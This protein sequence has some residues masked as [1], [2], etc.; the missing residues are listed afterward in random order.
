MSRVVEDHPLQA[1]RA[2]AA[3]HAWREAFD[4]LSESDRSE[5][6]APNDLT[7]LGDAAWWL[8]RLDESIAIKER[9]YAGYSGAGDRQKAAMCAL[10]LADLYFSK[11]AHSIG[12]GWFNRAERLL[13][14]EP[15]SAA[16]G[17]LAFMH[18]AGAERS[19]DLDAALA[20]G[21]RTLDLGTRFGDRDLQGYG[22][23]L[24]GR[25]LVLKGQVEEGLAL[26]DEATVAAVSGEIG[27]LATGI[28]YCLAISTTAALADYTR[29]GEWTDASKRWC[30]RQ[31]ISGFPGVCRVHRAE[32]MRLRG[33]WAEAEQEARRALTELERFNLEFAA[34][35]FYELGEIRLRIGD[36]ADAED[37]F[38]QAHEL[39]RPPYPGLA[40]LWLAQGK[41]EAAASAMRRALDDPHFDRLGR[42]RLLPAEVEVALALEDFERA[43]SAV[44]EL[45]E[46]AEHFDSVPLLASAG[47]ARG[48]LLLAQGDT[49][50]AVRTLESA[51]RLW[52]Q[53]DLPYEA[54]RT[55]MMLGVALRADGDDGGGTME[56]QAARSAFERLGA[57]LDLQAVMELLGGQ[58]GDGQPKASPPG[59]RVVKTMMFTDIVSSTSLLEAI[60][61]KAWEGVLDWHDQ[62]L[63]HLFAKHCGEEVKHAGDGFFVAFDQ[64]T[65]ALECA[66]EIQRRLADHRKNHGFAPQVRIGLHR[67]EATRKGHDYAGKGVHVAARVSAL[68]AA[69]EIL[70]TSDVMAHASSRFPASA[71]RTV[72]LKGVSDPVEVVAVAVSPLSVGPGA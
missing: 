6:L 48:A 47:C 43:G 20:L 16:H 38:R 36:L 17:Y 32:I 19:G 44:A 29:A 65:E 57:V 45:E 21:Q 51:W 52:K 4:L 71:P 8:G 42:C 27:P 54:A 72:A 28:I 24:R 10:S 33:S 14:D 62:T 12:A 34:E 55:R 30:E 63:R 3:K 7:T 64:A 15:E 56:I 35:G 26:L 2:A 49:V 22:L 68:A 67:A 46:T 9:A 60:G 50:A 25:A 37:A 5:Q 41:T 40:Q 70:A 53:A 1:G 39:G 13:E 69:G 18:A 31:A 11:L 66:A 59:V 58:A 23:L 61:D